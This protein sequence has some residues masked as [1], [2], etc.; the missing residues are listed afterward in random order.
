M[1]PIGNLS[2]NQTFV[3]S[4]AKVGPEATLPDAAL[5]S[6]DHKAFACPVGALPDLNL[7]GYFAG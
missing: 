7:E 5:T 6:N 1:A 4:A 2:P 3:E